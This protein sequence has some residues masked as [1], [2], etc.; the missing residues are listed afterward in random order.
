MKRPVPPQVF[1][2]RVYF[3]LAASVLDAV[4]SVTSKSQIADCYSLRE[5]PFTCQGG[6]CRLFSLHC[7]QASIGEYRVLL[8]IREEQL[9]LLGRIPHTSFEAELVRHFMRYYP[10]ECGRAGTAHVRELVCLGISRGLVH[11]YTAHREIGLFI[12]LMVMLGSGFTSDPQIPWA[13]AQLNDLAIDDPF[14]RIQ[15]VFR[16]SLQYLENCFGPKSSGMVKTLI[17]IRDFDLA[18][19]PR[20]VGLQLY[21]DLSKLFQ[22][23][24]PPK[25]SAQGEASTR[26][27]ISAGFDRA[28][29]YGVKSSVG[30]AVHITLMFMLGARFDED[31]LYPWAGQ[32]LRDKSLA[33]EATRVRSL[34][35]AAMQ[36]INEV[37]SE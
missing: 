23:L 12:N 24:C 9:N 8:L 3:W 34:H 20:S 32:V 17:R 35:N 25:Y 4:D 21:E 26:E 16:S 22:Y 14:Q 33:D 27:L 29:L 15:R 5:I 11:G 30:R 37:L 18:S 2:L 19:A 13:L 31:P 28:E 6:R 36:Y 1:D 10:H 7:S